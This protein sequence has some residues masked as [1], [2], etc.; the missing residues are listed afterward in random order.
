[1]EATDEQEEPLAESLAERSEQYEGF[2]N[3]PLSTNDPGLMWA[4][5]AVVCE[6]RLLRAALTSTEGDES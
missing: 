3:T 2:A 6:L 4:T 1:M 5:L